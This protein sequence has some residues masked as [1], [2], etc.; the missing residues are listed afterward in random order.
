MLFSA[1]LSLIFFH[2]IGSNTYK[3]L[4]DLSLAPAPNTSL[5]Y[6]YPTLTLAGAD[7]GV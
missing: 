7:M 5:S 1:S 4:H 3:A 6:V 2:V